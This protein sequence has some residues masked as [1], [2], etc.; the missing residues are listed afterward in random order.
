MPSPNTFSYDY[1]EL[2]ETEIQEGSLTSPFISISRAHISHEKDALSLQEE[3]KILFTG[4]RE[5]TLR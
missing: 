1:F 3:E 2:K 5:L 4:D